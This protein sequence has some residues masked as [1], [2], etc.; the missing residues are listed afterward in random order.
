MLFRS[1]SGGGAAGA[2]GA[3]TATNVVA[4]TVSAYIDHANV[5]TAAHDIELSATESAALWALSMGGAGAGAGGAGGGAVLAVAGA[6][7]VNVTSNKALAYIANTSVVTAPAAT[8][9]KLTATDTSAISAIGG[10]MAGSGAGGA[11]GGAAGAVGAS[12]AT[13]TTTNQVK[14][15]ID[16]SQVTSAGTIELKASET[17]IVSALSIGGAGARSEERRVGKEC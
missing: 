10:G 6:A 15:Y 2:V 13:N 17:G 8:S 1:G 4:N 9:V 11:G 12:V 14:A 5:S 16:S 3:S 7:S